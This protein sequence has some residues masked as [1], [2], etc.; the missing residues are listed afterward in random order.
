M[1][2]HFFMLVSLK[3]QCRAITR[4]SLHTLDRSQAFYSPKIIFNFVFQPLRSD[5][6]LG[7]M[8]NA[9]LFGTAR[10]V[11]WQNLI[12]IVRDIFENDNILWLSPGQG[13]IV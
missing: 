4:T 6:F 12:K 2:N 7:N 9:V 13:P 5:Y 10:S 1:D 3:N 11:Y 8:T